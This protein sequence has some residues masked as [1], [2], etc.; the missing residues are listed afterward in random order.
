MTQRSAALIIRHL[1]AFAAGLHDAGGSDV[2]PT[3]HAFAGLRVFEHRVVPVDLVLGVEVIRVGGGPVALQRRPDLT[4]VHLNTR[5]DGRRRSV[6][7][8]LRSTAV[9]GFPA[10]GR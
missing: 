8:G 2:S 5:T 4:I 3:A 9:F 7:D 10:G 6:Y 1:K